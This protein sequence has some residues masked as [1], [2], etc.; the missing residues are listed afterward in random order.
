MLLSNTVVVMFIIFYLFRK[1]TNR[2][3]EYTREKTWWY[4]CTGSVYHAAK[5]CQCTD[6]NDG[7]IF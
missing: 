1:H 7:K 2:G 5:L 6:C 4:C 3:D